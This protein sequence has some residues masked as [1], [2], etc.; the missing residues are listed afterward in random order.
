MKKAQI[1][2]EF[3]LI[4]GIM[5]ILLA[6]SVENVTFNQ[7]SQ[8]SE[9]LRVQ[10]SLEAKSFA[11]SISNTISQVYAQGPGSKATTY[12]TLRYLSDEN[13]LKKSFNLS[14]DP[15]IFITYLNGTYVGIIDTTDNTLV[16]SGTAKNTFWS[17]SLYETN[18]MGS[19]NFTPIGIAIYNGSTVNGIL[20]ANPDQLPT[21]L[22]IIVEW[23]PG[24]GN[25]WA[26]NV[27]TGELRINID[28]GG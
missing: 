8:S 24:N 6:Y 15:E 5:L 4:F 11:N 12:V 21:N 27:T 13:Y 26:L 9:L 25:T 23:I 19:T 18:L 1:S 7:G 14:G 10:V 2:L 16:T 28:P 17:R 3:M 22:V 20:I